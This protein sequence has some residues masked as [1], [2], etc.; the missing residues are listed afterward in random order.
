[1]NSFTGSLITEAKA[2]EMLKKISIIDEESSAATHPFCRFQAKLPKISEKIIIAEFC[3]R[4][5]LQSPEQLFQATS[6]DS[7][8]PKIREKLEKIFFFVDRQLREKDC[9]TKKILNLPE[10]IKP[11]LFCY[12]KSEK[13]HWGKA[14]FPKLFESPV[15]SDR[16]WL[17]FENEITLHLFA[18]F[19]SGASTHLAEETVRVRSP[20][21]NDIS[22]VL[23]LHEE[24]PQFLEF[25]VKTGAAVSF[26]NCASLPGIQHSCHFK[27]TGDFCLVGREKGN[28]I[29]ALSKEA[30]E[31]LQV[32]NIGEGKELKEVL[33]NCIGALELN[34][35]KGDPRAQFYLGYCYLMGKEMELDSQKAVE[36]L[37]KASLQGCLDAKYFLGMCL[38][39]SGVGMERDSWRALELLKQ[40]AHGGYPLAQPSL[41]YHIVSQHQIDVDLLLDCLTLP[42]PCQFNFSKNA[43]DYLLIEE[44]DVFLRMQ[45]TE[46]P[47][48]PKCMNSDVLYKM[49]NFLHKKTLPAYRGKAIKSML[50]D[51]NFE[52][53]PN[54]PAMTFHQTYKSS[55][56]P[57]SLFDQ[58]SIKN[59]FKEMARVIEH[60]CH[61]TANGDGHLYSSSISHAKLLF[62]QQ[63][64]A[65]F[66]PDTCTFKSLAFS[67]PDR[68]APPG[69]EMQKQGDTVQVAVY[70][71]I[72]QT[73]VSN[74]L[75][76]MLV[77]DFKRTKLSK[78]AH[79]VLEIAFR[80]DKLEETVRSELEKRNIQSDQLQR[81]LILFQNLFT[82][83][84]SWEIKQS[85]LFMSELL[86]QSTRTKRLNKFLKPV[87]NNRRFQ[88]HYIKQLQHVLN[89]QAYINKRTA[90]QSKGAF[91]TEKL[92]FFG[93]GAEVPRNLILGS[94]IDITRAQE[95]RKNKIFKEGIELSSNFEFEDKFAY[96]CKN[97]TTTE[98]VTQQRKQMIVCLVC[99]CDP[100][101]VEMKEVANLRKEW[102]SVYLQLMHEGKPVTVFS[103][104]EAMLVYPLMMI[105]YSDV[106]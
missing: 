43:V 41:I 16:T 4:K 88:I 89:F 51:I 57:F 53:V 62:K 55:S 27:F 33:K 21:L 84:K 22:L 52:N 75:E 35:H 2:S 74:P 72:Q 7:D 60:I 34:A 68:S 103:V 44:V 93:P 1:M 92:L 30:K 73:E 40:A 31:V 105:E 90:F 99:I 86:Q 67:L 50:N 20:L 95:R 13:Y 66:V 11:Q 78:E 59:K 58:L 85:N 36:W 64:Q 49:V 76:R 46:Q 77:G 65:I 91:V 9:V 10:Q 70:S 81:N 100:Q 26:V 82:P 32:P 19:F 54:L 71:W 97:Q 28:K 37:H 79:S 63:S 24:F 38:L 5:L 12:Q 39:D 6:L 61:K 29:I 47:L 48:D 15:P 80:Q 98:R 94:Y 56:T 102:E 104:R 18:Q 106:A 83:Y 42:T 96:H 23:A 87:R 25:V 69:D 101:K 45:G 14:E 3:V 17:V 8:N